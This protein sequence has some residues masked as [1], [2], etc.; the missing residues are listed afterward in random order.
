MAHTYEHC[1][2]QLSYQ[3]DASGL[4]DG[5]NALFD[6]E[7][8]LDPDRLDRLEGYL[9]AQHQQQTDHAGNVDD[10]AMMNAMRAFDDDHPPEEVIEDV[11]EE[12]IELYSD[13][14]SVSTCEHK[15]DLAQDDE[16][17]PARDKAETT[18]TT[19][20]EE[21]AKL[22]D[23]FFRFNCSPIK[24]SNILTRGRGEFSL[25][26]ICRC[27]CFAASDSLA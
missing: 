6:L 19:T 1:D 2:E 16:F 11:P 15:S 13:L 12:V 26:F 24:F 20:A 18:A 21:R 23:P 22:L 5:G 4:Q 7:E 9:F 3:Y 17:E 10:E 27:F 14:E 8:H 25:Q